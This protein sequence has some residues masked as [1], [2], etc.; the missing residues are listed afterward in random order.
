MKTLPNSIETSC[1]FTPPIHA[2]P[3]KIVN[4]FLR[5]TGNSNRKKGNRKPDSSRF[6][7]VFPLIAVNRERKENEK[8]KKKEKKGTRLDRR[9]ERT[10]HSSRTDDT[11]G[12]K[13]G[14]KEP[15]VY[16]GKKLSIMG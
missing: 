8:R 14:R 16:N 4:P 6:K 3:C 9:N 7:V 5:E 1:F 12:R 15:R 11:S 13:E 10:N 2:F